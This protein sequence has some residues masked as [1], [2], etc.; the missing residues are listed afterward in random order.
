MKTVQDVV[1]EMKFIE[2]KQKLFGKLIG[3]KRK[4]LDDQDKE[5]AQML[6]DEAT[7]EL[8]VFM[9]GSILTQDDKQPQPEEVN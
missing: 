6:H 4:Q 8:Q 3:P 9:N 5:V 7:K 1:K 2:S